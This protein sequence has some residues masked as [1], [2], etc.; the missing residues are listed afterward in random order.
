MQQ[1]GDVKKLTSGGRGGGI[2]VVGGFTVNADAATTVSGNGQQA[3]A[4]ATAPFKLGVY[5]DPA[6]LGTFAATATVTN[7][8][9][10]LPW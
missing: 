1:P 9:Y 2:A 7:S 10:Q 8:N 5:L 4:P 6:V 3:P